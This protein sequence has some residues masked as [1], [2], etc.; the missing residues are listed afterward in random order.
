MT[1]PRR[2]LRRVQD[3]RTHAG[4]STER[5]LPHQ[6]YLRIACLEMEK[7]RREQERQSAMRRVQTIDARFNEIKAE[8]M[9]LMQTMKR[10]VSR[11]TVVASSRTEASTEPAPVSQ[12]FRIRY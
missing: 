12:G 8:Q 3:I 10:D 2:T 9:S 5:T 1:V 11:K 4:I 7:F 6:V